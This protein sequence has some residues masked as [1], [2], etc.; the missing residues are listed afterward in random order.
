MEATPPPSS[1]TI[2]PTLI[3]PELV[4]DTP[5]PAVTCDPYTVRVWKHKS[6]DAVAMELD[7]VVKVFKWS[8]V[9][10]SYVKE[11][12]EISPLED[13]S[14]DDYEFQGWALNR[15]FSK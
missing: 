14:S 15:E 6:V 4:P 8:Q 3:V 1:A 13:F 11:E 12:E 2:D 10:E 9:G 7:E 5:A